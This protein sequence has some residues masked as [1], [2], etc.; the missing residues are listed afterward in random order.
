MKTYRA[1]WTGG[2]I[3]ALTFSSFALLDLVPALHGSE[4]K[5]GFF[6]GIF[7]II[8]AFLG[9]HLYY[10]TGDKTHGLL[11]GTFMT[12]IALVLDA[13]ITVPV[14]TIPQNGSY[15]SFYFNPIL[16]LLIVVNI[17]SVFVYWKCFVATSANAKKVMADG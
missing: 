3:W 5:Q 13:L 16:W 8:Y 10:K 1:L 15:A 7:I 2:I 12:G 9:A 17:S 14:V 11:V 4:T 6:V